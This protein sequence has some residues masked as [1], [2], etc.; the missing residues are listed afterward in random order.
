MKQFILSLNLKGVRVTTWVRL[1]LY[2]VTV[3]AVC[4]NFV[5]INIPI[6]TES[7]A[8]EIVSL[9]FMVLVLL[10]GYW[11]NNSFTK[12]AQEMDDILQERKGM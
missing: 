11:K 4:L 12:L 2:V 10:Q 7:A 9:V 5:G 8:T 6:I 3:C 1:L